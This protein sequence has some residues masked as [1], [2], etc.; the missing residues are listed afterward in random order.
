MNKSIFHLK[1]GAGQANHQ[2]GLFESMFTKGK[3]MR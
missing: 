2:I 3:K 1:K